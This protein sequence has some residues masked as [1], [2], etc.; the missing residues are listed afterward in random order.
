MKYQI[1]RMKAK[2]FAAE[3]KKPIYIARAKNGHH[4]VLL[5]KSM[6]SPRYTIIEEIRP[7][8]S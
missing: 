5:S 3:H 1:A 7:E 6:C 8:V 4:E 2:E